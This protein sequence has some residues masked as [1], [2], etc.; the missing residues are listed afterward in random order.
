M[1]KTIKRPRGKQD[2]PQVLSKRMPE[3]KQFWF[4]LWHLALML[5]G[6]AVLTYF[7]LRL[8]YS[9][10]G[11]EIWLGYWED[12]W[13]PAINLL[14][15]YAFCLVLFALLGRAW[16]AYLLTAVVVL[17]IAV[18]NYYLIIIRTDALQFQDLT[19]LREALAITGTQGYELELTPT[20]LLSIGGALGFTALLA[21]LSRWRPRW[22]LSRWIG[23]L[24]AVGVLTGVTALAVSD[25]I[26]ALTKNYTHINT[27]SVTQIYASR[28]VILPFTRSIFT[29]SGKPSNY[30]KE[31]TEALLNSYI[32]EDIP[33][34]R[35]VDIFVVMRESYSDLSE[36]SCDQDA[37]DFSCYDLYHS[38]RDEAVL[39]GN[40]VTNG[41]GGNTKD[42]ERAFLA[43]NYVQQ[44]W[45]KPTNSYVWYLK[46]QGYTAEGAHPFNGWFYNRQNVAR[47]MGF[48]RYA[49]REDTFDALVGEKKIADDDVLYD[50]IWQQYQEHLAES[51]A[52]YF[53]FSV[54]YEGHGPYSYTKN[55]YPGRYVKRDAKT[56]D[57]YAMNN[58]LGC[59]A[60]RDDELRLLVDHFRYSTERPIVLLIYGDH[61]ATLGKDINNYTTAAYARYGMDMS[62][63][64]ESGFFNYYSTDYVIW[65]NDAAK[66]K[67]GISGKTKAGPTISPCYLMNVLFDTLGWGKGP[68]YL[69]AMDEM[70]KAFPVYSTKGR[71]SINGKLRTSIPAS[72]SEKYHQMKNL[73]YYWQTEFRYQALAE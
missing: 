46:E 11:E 55:N 41:F 66:Q 65:M 13:I 30:S 69:Q 5:L 9:N 39:W 57:G 50:V 24:A 56:P 3:R 8:S 18:G 28:G 40:L 71:V 38:L 35:Q 22:K 42:A 15:I 16:L 73:S 36:L 17:G 31:E 23:L 7:T 27:W 60:K 67:L 26:N 52:P 63:S 58:Y 72:W 34:D 54:T 45:R 20:I 33:E 48:D 61:K 47:Y 25:K 49:F 12:L 14:L 4:L 44:E 64:T 6:C 70:M 37:I 51:D 10:L 43:G 32:Q 62:L 68:A 1:A 53:N 59:C 19:C 29:G 21:L 2:V